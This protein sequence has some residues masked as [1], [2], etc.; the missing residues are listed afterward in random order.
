MVAIAGKGWK[1]APCLVDLFVEADRLFPQRSNISDGSIG[2]PAHASRTSDHN[3]SGGYV[4]AADLTDDKANGC[5][6]DLLARHLVAT[7]DPR[8]K[9]VIWNRTIVASYPRAGIPAWT[10]APYTGVN[11]HASHTHISVTISGRDNRRPWFPTSQPPTD[12]EDDDMAKPPQIYDLRGKQ[13]D[14]NIG[15]HT[16]IVEDN[17]ITAH[18]LDQPQADEWVRWE[19]DDR[20][21]R[22][23]QDSAMFHCLDGPLRTP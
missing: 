1:L 14:G 17:G 5:D 8:V 4:H 22:G 18:H 11:A 20:R 3:P 7:R 9:Y 2:D 21:D 10:P 6:A 23:P 12:T 16:Y 19:A 15:T 13:T